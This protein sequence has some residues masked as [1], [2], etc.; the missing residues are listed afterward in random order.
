MRSDL[1]VDMGSSF[2]RAGERLRSIAKMNR[3]AKTQ[4]EGKVGDTDT[5][6]NCYL[7]ALPTE[8]LL[9]IISHLSVLPEACLAL[10]CKRLYSI[11]GA[12][13]GAKPLHFSRDFAPLFHHYR[14]G[15][16]FVTPRWQFIN[17]LED[18]RWRACSRCLKL[19][20]RSFFPAR[21][22]KRKSEDRSCNLG[23][24][25]GIVDLC[26]CK[27]LTFQDKMELVE[28]LRVRRKTITDLAV[29]FGSGMKQQRFCWHSCTED[30]GS[31]QL[32]IEIYP[33]LDD[34]DQ[35]K[36]KTEYRLRTGS[37]QLGKEEHMTPR[38]G[39]AH[40][41][42]DLW[43]S[44]YMQQ[45]PNLPHH[46]QTIHPQQLLYNSNVNTSASP[47]QYGKPVVYPQV[48]IPAYPAYAQTY[49]PQP[50]QQQQPPPP[51]PQQPPPQQQPQQQYVNP[52]DL[53]NPPPLASTSP[54]QF[55]NSPSQ[56]AAQP[57][58]SVAGNSRSPVLPT[59]TPARSTYYSAPSPNQ[60][61]QTP[62]NYPQPTST[63][64]SVQ[65]PPPAAAAVAATASPAPAPAAK[66]VAANP[67]P[68]K[69]AAAKPVAQTPPA[70]SP[71]PVQVLIPAPTPEVQQKVQR[72]PIKKQAQRQTGQKPTQ[73]SAGTPIDYQVLLLAMA[74]EYLNA[75]HS[76]GTLVAL[77]RREME[78]DEY[79]KLVATGLGCLEAVLK[80]WR[81]QPRVEA[82]VRLRYARILFEETDNDLEAETALS[83]GIDLCERN[84]MLDLKYSMQHLLARMLYKTNPKASLKAVDGMIQDVEAYVPVSPILSSSAEP[85]RYRH[86]AWEY[87]FRFLRVSLSLSS[88]AHQDSV[89]ALQ[90]LHKIATMASRNG[91]RAVSA[92]SAIIEALAHLQQGSGFDSV[93][94][95]Q[96]AVAVARSHQLNDELRHIPQLTTLVQIVDICC[97]LLEY[98]INQSSQ[99]L[100]VLQD[101]MDERLN[102][103]NWRSDGSFSIPLNGKS[104]GP[105]SID[106]GDI[107]QVQSGTLLLSF[108]WLPQHDLY[109]LCYFLSSITLSCKNSYDGRK[110][111]K[112]LQEGTRMLKG[113]FKA[114]Q[115]ITESV[116]S[117]NRRVQWRRLLYCNLLVQQV[118]LACGRTD[119]ELANKT[120]KELR[121]EGQELGDQLP[122][123]VECL[124]EYATGA[125]AQATGDLTA[126]LNA[127]QSPLLSLSTN[128]SK[129]ARNEPRRDIA[130]L[131]ALNTVLILRDPTHP[132]HSHLPTILSTVESF[133]TGSPNKYIQAAYYLVCATVQTESTIQTKQYL[134]QALQS[135]TAISNSQIT[136]MTLTFMSWK[137]FRGVVG[138]QAEKSARAGRAM[139]KKAND[140]LWVSVTDEML[141]ETLERQG[142]NEEA[143][144][145]REEGHRVMMGLPSALK[146]PV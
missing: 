66:P 130:I 120:L 49:N 124:M 127:F 45:P 106:T 43:L 109:A 20:P 78:M 61:N 44:S 140:R 1:P 4:Y 79:Y 101:L 97:S 88:S 76:H 139:A 125:I 83:K 32:D 143:K 67:V 38:F 57:A 24:S 138:E 33:E 128:F 31:T 63:T 126:A 71:K 121:E 9:E 73:K 87:A 39:C 2:R 105:S 91:D 99:K 136:C 86:S 59:S 113:S 23:S 16:N 41:S 132:S 116:V 90:H 7:L 51:P 117:A 28:L 6:T 21:E 135:A 29:Q 18:N 131:A 123:T 12:T 8:L 14:N 111:E 54:P 70:P 95:A 82:L 81:L 84:R 133:C 13:L 94:Q 27:K 48:M 118:F 75:A 92:M 144:G 108:N 137:Y 72:P 36:I 119:W 15:H 3:W 50:P 122:D 47:Y 17:L 19:H 64:P 37:G 80:N 34:E 129:T 141:A 114:P 142:K 10:T 102:D 98:D 35:L 56:Y 52:S 60:A 30:Y 46:Q 96:R 100:K 85:V 89:S 112:F 58:V 110:A 55:T 11:C 103:S 74:D 146:R 115:E 5:I 104:A 69:P 65:V 62:N 22:L 53:F 42:V 77:L 145:V 93:E 68:V 107:L 40:R 25:A 26:P 134:Q